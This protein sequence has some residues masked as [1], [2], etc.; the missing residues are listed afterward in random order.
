[1][2]L[3]LSGKGCLNNLTVVDFKLQMKW[4]DLDVIIQGHLFVPTIILQLPS[5]VRTNEGRGCKHC[6]SSKVIE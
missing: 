6:L 4:Q 5:R 1:M 2:T 3:Y